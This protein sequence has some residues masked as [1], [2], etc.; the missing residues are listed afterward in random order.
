MVNTL[1]RLYDNATRD[2]R[3]VMTQPEQPQIYLVTPPAF[4]LSAFPD[5]LAR[6]LDAHDIACLRLSLA[7]RDEDT[8]ARAADALR[9]VVHA[10]DVAIVIETHVVLAQRLG[11]DGVHLTDG[12]RTVRFARKELGEDAIVGSFCGQSRHD[13]IS[14]G[15]SGADYVSFGPVGTNALG[16]GA[17]APDDLFSWWSEMIELPVVAEGALDAAAIRRLAPMTDFF[18]IGDE[19]WTSDDPSGALHLLRQAMA[20]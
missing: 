17:Q 7:T 13:G 5:T 10:R 15:E 9:D 4:D 6:V 14:A 2:K 19:I 8:L 12:A 11:L 20:G 1:P 16:D 3:Q 18:A